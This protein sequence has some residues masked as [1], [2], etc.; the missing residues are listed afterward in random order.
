MMNP[1]VKRKWLKALRS[2]EYTQTQGWL[3][4]PECNRYEHCCLGVL[5][6]EMVPEFVRPTNAGNDIPG[7]DNQTGTLPDDLAILYGLDQ[8][9]QRLLSRK[10][11]AGNS[12][13]DIADW[14]EENL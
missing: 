7:V 14:I 12:F 2:G 9:T 4:S 13:D 8:P 6:C 11:D 3:V 1:W 10:N 5:A